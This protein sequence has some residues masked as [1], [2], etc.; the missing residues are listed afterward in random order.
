[1]TTPEERMNLQN[2]LAR[3]QHELRAPKD[4]LNEFGGFT[5]RNQEEILA[6]VKPLLTDGLTIHLTDSVELI[7][8]RYY[9][10]ATALITDG[11]DSITASGWARETESKKGM[12]DAQV[13]GS[14]SSYARKYALCGLLAI[15]NEKDADAEKP[16]DKSK[17][18]I[19]HTQA[20]KLKELIDETETDEEKFFAYFKVQ[21]LHELTLDQYAKA[22]GQL[23]KK[24]RAL[25]GD[26]GGR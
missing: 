8:E 2:N 3:I 7:G 17:E 13:T 5:Y 14:A 25:V 9:V 16:V 22:L 10:K 11:K 19:D 26:G 24:K 4:K 12:D 15:D 6:S 20:R 1:M 18:Q 21:R 23:Q